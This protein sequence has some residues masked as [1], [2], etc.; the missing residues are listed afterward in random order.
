MS[1]P[2]RRNSAI[3][4]D[5]PTMNQIRAELVLEWLSSMDFRRSDLKQVGAKCMRVTLF[6][7]TVCHR[8]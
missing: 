6:L 4:L 7:R 3:S 1:Y 2:L 8:R 5:H